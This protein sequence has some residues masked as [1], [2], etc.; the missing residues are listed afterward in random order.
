[1]KC[2]DIPELPILKFLLDRKI[3]G[4]GWATSFSGYENS[5]DQAMK[6]VPYKL[7]LAKMKKLIARGLVDGC[8]CGCSGDFEITEIGEKFILRCGE[9]ARHTSLCW[10]LGTVATF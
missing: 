10:L 7:V 6:G 2:S 5:I 4:L 3:K 1:M 9:V 8:A